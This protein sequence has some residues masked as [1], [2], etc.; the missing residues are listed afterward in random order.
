MSATVRRAMVLFPN[1]LRRINGVH[2]AAVIRE[3]GKVLRAKKA[4]DAEGVESPGVLLV[5][6]WKI[7]FFF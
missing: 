2:D 5:C 7:N 4:C 1:T 6:C 3:Q